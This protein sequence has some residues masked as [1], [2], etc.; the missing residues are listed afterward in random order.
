M[1][2]IPQAEQSEQHDEQP[3]ILPKHYVKLTRNTKGY[4]WEISCRSDDLK[5]VMDTIA[6]VDQVCRKQYGNA[7]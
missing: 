4:N 6:F 3:V 2:V 5:E 7:E 1:T